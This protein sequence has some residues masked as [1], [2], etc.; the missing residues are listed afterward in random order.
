MAS[1]TKGISAGPTCPAQSL[2]SIRWFNGWSKEGYEWYNILYQHVKK[3]C[4]EELGASFGWFPCKDIWW[5]T[6]ERESWRSYQDWNIAGKFDN[7]YV[8]VHL[9]AC[10]HCWHTL[11][12]I[13]TLDLRGLHKYWR[14]QNMLLSTPSEN[15]NLWIWRLICKT[16]SIWNTHQR[17]QILK[18]AKKTQKI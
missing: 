15:P 13:F 9:I 8:Q 10:S 3:D 5:T 4:Q 14:H 17:T 7:V 2:A 16:S 18:F 6:R 12:Y 1:K 11:F